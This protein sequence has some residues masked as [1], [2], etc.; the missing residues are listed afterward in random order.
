MGIITVENSL[1]FVACFAR[2]VAKIV[3]LCVLVKG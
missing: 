2:F 1:G 3:V